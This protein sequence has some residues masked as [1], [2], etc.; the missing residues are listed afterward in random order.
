MW[1][2]FLF[3]LFIAVLHQNVLGTTLI[4]CHHCPSLKVYHYIVTN[5]TIPNNFLEQC[6]YRMSQRSCSIEVIIDFDTKITTI[7]VTSSTEYMETSIN[8]IIN[9]KDE[10]K[11]IRHISF[12]CSNPKGGCNDVYY[13]ENVFKS[14]S[15]KDS[16]KELESLLIPTN[17]TIFNNNSCVTFSNQTTSIE[18]S[19]EWLEDSKACFISSM[20]NVELSSK[21]CANYS[22]MNNYYLTQAMTFF[23]NNYSI[24]QTNHRSLLCAVNECNSMENLERIDQLINV[25]FDASKFFN[26]TTTTTTTT[27]VSSTVP[28][29]SSST[30]WLNKSINYCNL[31]LFLLM[32]FIYIVMLS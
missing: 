13:L 30:L 12:W 17:Q 19:T 9:I 16:S 25:D 14:I 18:C 4:G 26:S 2:Q 15:I 29:G 31:F 6:S 8:T 3:I 22:S 10:L 24:S 7:N 27:I 20:T 1:S 23:I 21:I 5:E 11:H 32:S 28:T